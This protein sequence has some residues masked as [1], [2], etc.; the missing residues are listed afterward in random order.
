MHVCS[1]FETRSVAHILNGRCVA[2]VLNGAAQEMC[3]TCLEWASVVDETVPAV[4]DETV[5]GVLH[6]TMSASSS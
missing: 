5:C 1:V 6:A 3:G 4:L 2:H